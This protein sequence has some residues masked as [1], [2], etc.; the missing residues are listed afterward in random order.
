MPFKTSSNAKLTGLCVA[1]SF[2]VIVD[3]K[4]SKYYEAALGNF[5]RARHCYQRAGLAA[6][7]EETVRRVCTAHFRKSG[8]IGK[9]QA[10]RVVVTTHTTVPCPIWHTGP[11]IPTHRPSA[12]P[13]TTEIDAHQVA[14]RPK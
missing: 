3:A 9:F 2:A 11:W 13:A 8:F 7:W 6:D 5:A 4:K 12:P 1:G 10:L 14:H